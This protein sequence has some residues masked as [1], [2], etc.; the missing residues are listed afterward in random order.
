MKKKPRANKRA[1]KPAPASVSPPSAPLR[2]V[3][4]GG[5]AGGLEALEQ[6]FAN[7][8]PDTGMAFVLVTHMDPD[9]KGLLAQLIQRTTAMRV[10]EA[11]D[12]Q[13]VES[14]SVYVIPPNREIVIEGGRLHL[15]VAG[16]RSG[17]RKPIDV[18]FTSL[19]KDRGETAVGVILSGMGAD[20]TVGLHAIRDHGG[21]ALVQA[22][23]TAA[24][25]SMP[26]S[27]IAAGSVDVVAAPE[28]LP[29]HLLAGSVRLLPARD[30]SE[31]A[32]ISEHALAALFQLLH[33]RTGHDFS[34][35]KTGAIHRRLERRIAVHHLDS[36]GDYVAY[37]EA[38][39]HETELLFKEL[40]IGVTHFFRE[41][42]GQVSFFV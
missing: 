16:P 4:L 11:E 41:P 37:L 6:F 34:E 8:P 28:A 13:L 29:S 26:R 22:P 25:D 1:R 7:M 23:E 9:H 10:C 42:A 27:A 24:Y 14:D 36:L 32:K 30:R 40:L 20:G 3:G 38:N 33:D 15:R 21:T 18:F 31:E 39:P 2:V 12:G 19:A 35:Y 5:S 17:P